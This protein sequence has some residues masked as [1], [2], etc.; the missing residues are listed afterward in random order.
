MLFCVF[1][2]EGEIGSITR[3]IYIHDVISKKKKTGSL[4]SLFS[5]MDLA[6]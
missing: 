3:Y 6:T 5:F 1:V 4:S 2:W